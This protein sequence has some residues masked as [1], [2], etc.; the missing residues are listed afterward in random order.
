MV[1]IL[2]DIAIGTFK[3][4][5]YFISK[6]EGN[7]VIVV[8]NNKEKKVKAFDSVVFATETLSNNTI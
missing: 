1:E 4:V 6:I 3:N 5:F 8:K 2:Y 7:S